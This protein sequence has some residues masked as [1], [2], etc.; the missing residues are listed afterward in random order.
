MNVSGF[1]TVPQV[2]ASTGHPVWRVR[3]VV[4]QCLPDCPRAGLVRLVPASHV[5]LIEE[6]LHAQYAW[7]DELMP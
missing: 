6:R 7:L 1:F 4:D 2:A 5:P 3:R